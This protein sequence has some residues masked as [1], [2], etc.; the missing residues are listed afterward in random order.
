MQV[1]SKK[2]PLIGRAIALLST[3]ERVTALAIAA[4]A[5]VAG[6][7]EAMIIVLVLPIA[8]LVIDPAS[9][10]QSSIG[11]LLSPW[12]GI[13]GETNPA[14]WLLVA[15]I[16]MLVLSAAVRIVTLFAS[17][18]HAAA[19]RTRLS[20]IILAKLIEAPLDW[21]MRRNSAERR[22]L[23]LDDVNLWRGDYLQNA[24]AALQ[25]VFLIA[26]PAA[27]VI[28]LASVNGLVALVVLG[29]IVGLIVASFRPKIRLTATQEMHARDVAINRLVQT[30]AGLREVKLSAK[31]P[32]FIDRFASADGKSAVWHVRARF[33]S[34]LPGVCVMTFGQVGFLGAALMLWLTE[35]SAGAAAANLMMIGILVARVLPAFNALGNQAARL[36]KSAPIVERILDTLVE[37]D[38]AIEKARRIAPTPFPENWRSVSLRNVSKGFA[39]ERGKA[40]HDVTAKLE[41]G[42]IYG[43]VGRSGAGK[44]T[45]V[46]IVVGILD[47][48]DGQVFLDETPL[49][50]I[51]PKDWYSRIGYV[52]QSPF[53]LETSVS[54]NVAFGSEPDTNRVGRALAQ[55]QMGS[56]VEE[57]PDG[58]RT[59]VGERGGRLSGGQIQRITIARALYR[60]PELLVFDEA[61]SALDQETERY[62]HD[63]V[64]V[65]DMSR[66]TV[67]I[68]HRVNTLSA[69]DEILFLENGRLLASGTLDA[70][71]CDLPAFA[72]MLDSTAETSETPKPP[73]GDRLYGTAPK[74][75]INRIKE[76]VEKCE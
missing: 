20:R 34:S 31:A 25:S 19:C 9:F 49:A 32:F 64:T 62:I 53:V 65:R 47:P 72:A 7:I 22:T 10:G 15:T 51:D 17:E 66:L 8:Y 60:E 40:L 41:R 69:C 63:V 61:T 14:V 33:V 43:L 54:E 30:L 3:R 46:N 5:A 35:E 27:A 44:T 67:I 56:L 42:K 6:L 28:A 4:I 58:L 29:G 68:S 36:S 24:L 45:L 13:F 59:N 23:I 16:A 70:L 21:S 38:A 2:G 71:K 52:L 48:T 76:P 74:E 26:F 73:S 55:A 75:G 11:K 12:M 37:L 39:D 1:G 18:K 50:D 57:M